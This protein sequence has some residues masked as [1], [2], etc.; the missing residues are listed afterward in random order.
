MANAPELIQLQSA[1]A[2]P[3]PEQLAVSSD[4]LLN[5]RRSN[6]R[7]AHFPE[8]VYDLSAESHLSRFIKVLLGDAGANQVRK[9]FL[10]A[11]LRSNLQGSHFLD[12]DRFY[13]ALFRVR[14]LTEERLTIDPYWDSVTSEQWALEHA[15]DASY[16][17]RI[18]QFS[19]AIGYGAT[20]TGMETVAEALLTVDCDIYE[21]WVQADASYRTIGELEQNFPTVAD[22]EG[23]NIGFLEGEGLQRLAGDERRL[24][25]VRPKR[26]ITLEEAYDLTRVL[27]Q[28]KPSEARFI[29]EPQGIPVHLPVPVRNVAADSIY[30]EVIPQVASRPTNLALHPY[31]I[32][33][34]NPVEQP[35]PPFSAYQGEAW[36][37]N[38]D[39]IGV[40]AYTQKDASGITSFKMP[41]QRLTFSDSSYLDYYPQYVV[42]SQKYVQ[43]GRNVSDG[44]LVSNPFATS[45]DGSPID[46]LYADRIPLGDLSVALQ[47]EGGNPFGTQ[48]GDRYWITPERPMEDNTREI[49]EF[50]FNETHLINNVSFEVAHFPQKVA[51]D[52]FNNQN[53]KW[54]EVFTQNITDSVP[55]YLSPANQL[56][57]GD[58]HPQHSAAN[59]WVKCKG[60]IEPRTAAKARIVL[61][62]LDGIPP[63]LRKKY[64]VYQSVVKVPELASVPYS[65]AVRSLDVGYRISSRADIPANNGEV[66]DTSVDVLGS[67]VQF[68]VREEPPERVLDTTPKSWKS[69]PQPFNY[70]VVNFYADT[71][72][73][74]GEGQVI[75]RF[76][77]EPTHTGPHISIYY[78]N[79]DVVSVDQPFNLLHPIDAS[80]EESIGSWQADNNA[81]VSRSNIGNTEG[82]V[83]LR[84]KATGNAPT[85]RTGITNP[86]VLPVDGGME[87]TAIANVFA[88]GVPTLGQVGVRWFNSGKVQI[89]SDVFS[90]GTT[91][92]VTNP[93]QDALHVTTPFNA[94]YAVLL[95]RFPN[96]VSGDVFDCDAFGFFPGDNTTWYPPGP[97]PI[98]GL[99]EEDFRDFTWIPVP[100]D[101]TLQKGILQVP[102]IRAKYWKFEF[103]NLTAEPYESLVPILRTV[104]LFSPYQVNES[105]RKAG[106]VSIS[107]TPDLISSS[108]TIG[109]MD[110]YQ[111]AYQQIVSNFPDSRTYSPT[112]ALYATD[113]E[114]AQRLG[115]ASWFYNFS[116]WHQGD[117]APR[118]IRTQ[119]HHYTEVEIYTTSKVAFFVGLKDFRAY[120][121]AYEADDDTQIIHDRFWDFRNIEPGFTWNFNPNS[122]STANNNDCVATSR[123]INTRHN[124]KAVQFAT[125]QTEPIQLV[126]DHDF[127]DPALSTY[128]W[129]D[130]DNWTKV[131]DVTLLYN[132]S[133]DSVQMLRYV[134]PPQ[135]ALK[136]TGGLIQG[137]VQ[138]VFSE[139]TLTFADEAAAAA[140]YGGIESGLLGPSDK[141]RIYAAARVTATKELTNPLLLQIISDSTGEVLAENTA[142]AHQGEMV[143]WYVGY[144]LKGTSV[145]DTVR[146]RLI[147]EGKVNDSWR[148]DTL[149]LFD[150]GII[151][152]FSVDGG[153]SFYPARSIRNNPN[154]V[155]T[156][157]D[158]GNQLVWR[159]KGA[160][161]YMAVNS[162]QIRPWFVGIQNS[163]FD[164]AH[165]GPNVSMYDQAPPI[166]DDPE[167]KGWDKPIPRSWFYVAQRFPTLPVTDA[168]NVTEF[169]RFYGR[170]FS[171]TLATPTDTATPK[172]FLF[173]SG[174]EAMF[175]FQPLS[176]QATRQGKFFRHTYDTLGSPGDGALGTYIA[177]SSDRIINIPVHPT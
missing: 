149:S 175:F 130:D 12:L 58:P 48:Q 37:Y 62:R 44:I 20:P 134:V 153:N 8:E 69:E 60:R 11:R 50:R 146:V 120:R 156:F 30:W 57:V 98:T 141:G 41:V 53:G 66:I 94:A 148:L 7:L 75:D 82:E 23:K 19:R 150:E 73:D 104:K 97:P 38:A 6:D 108:F 16:R 129:D 135:K 15:R 107:D 25:V 52:I 43:A 84:L 21:S 87:Y 29:I 63:R 17:S 124:I 116:P 155:L 42:L 139:R 117:A 103:T 83:S 115:D 64:E 85:V 90:A 125:Q 76:Y 176:E 34:D 14:R 49:I 32:A 118:F 99:T 36:S 51:F 144:D 9:R 138:P 3:V 151:W 26:P 22:L 95:V 126:P 101:Y 162:L 160:R 27:T 133:D 59:H 45:R 18:E 100:R 88:A 131:G 109:Q 123:A 136:R 33:S 72:D 70:A 81:F 39:I 54:E 96:A 145:D 61:T 122:L 28:L 121:V 119:Q 78:S 161:N 127:K 13:G 137:I 172:K 168:P 157:P 86:Y 47:A 159:V 106:G 24:F 77:L 68:S 142:T 71:R 1:P 105:L 46:D 170:P 154:G 89:G 177:P 165:R 174:V 158:P 35:R 110:R 147:Q 167:F 56:I 113:P 152:E 74:D 93:V 171:E 166:Q 10:L 67:L 91:T 2:I 128:N 4:L 92:V 169:Q 173:R 114:S 102:P 140:T 164:G 111:D 132:A 55:K 143:E 65:L 79:Q 31:Q 112:D 5:P 163:R 80:V 40:V